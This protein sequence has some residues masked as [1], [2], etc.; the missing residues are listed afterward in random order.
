MDKKIYTIALATAL[1]TPVVQAQDTYLNDRL[2]N[3][4]DLIG[5]ARYVGMGGAMGALGAD[6][7]LMSS[8]PAGIGL[9]RRADLAGTVSVMTQKDHSASG[10][11]YTHFSFDQLGFVYS[12]KFGGNS[13]NY[14]NFGVNYQKKI[15]FNH[16]MIADNN[17]LGG[18]SQ[19]MLLADQCNRFPPVEDENGY[20]GYPT[21]LTGATY[22]AYVFDSD[23]Q[24]YFGDPAFRNEYS[25]VTG[26]SL[27]GFDFNLAFNLK[28]RVFLGFTFGVDN[29]DYN[30]RSIYTEYR[31]GVTFAGDAMALDYSLLTD[32]VVSGYGVNFKLGAIVRPFEESAFR[33]GL[34]VESPTYY[35]LRSS[36]GSRIESTF[37]REG[38]YLESGIYTHSGIT[39]DL[40][41]DLRTPWKVRV[42]AG[43]TVGT[44][45]AIGAEYEYANYGKTSMGYSTDS[46]YDDVWSNEK[47][48]AM[49]RLTEQ[50]L[51]GTHTFKVGLELKPADNLS[52]RAGYNHISKSFKDNAR[53]D[54]PLESYAALYSHHT[55]YMNMG[56]VNL[57]TAGIGYRFKHFYVDLAYKY[58]RQNAEFYAFDDSFTAGADFTGS[59][60]EG[61]SLRPVDVN[62]TR[63]Q[64]FF[65]LGYKF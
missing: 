39:S 54:L 4:G 33:V 47:D 29:V 9:Y 1:A 15:N 60:Y 20:W 14:V 6:L 49:N 59:V 51:Q 24:G 53:F 11:D 30:S 61:M 41:F 64:A 3:G 57:F 46:Y 42:S 12:A 40:D 50:T 43:H 18:L 2:T 62:L 21:D 25:R 26:G 44:I 17:G 37:D 45:F 52:L 56:D 31:D 23:E 63:H 65:T 35:S 10:E 27:Q 5:T 32:H 19:S 58:R 55:D 38:Y 16:A 7:S 22:N 48:R 36:V 13:L 8:N 28:D 34:A